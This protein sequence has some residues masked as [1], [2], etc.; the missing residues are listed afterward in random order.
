MIEKPFA[1]PRGTIY[2]DENEKVSLEARNGAIQ[3]Q[4]ILH[5]AMTWENGAP[6]SPALLLTLQQLAV[7]Q[8]YRC[9]GHFRNEGVI[10]QDATSGEILFKP[11]E[12]SE[13]PGLVQEMCDYVNQNRTTRTPVHLAAYAMW[14]LNWIHPFFGG[15]GRTSRAFSYLVLCIGLRFVPPADQKTI[16]QYIEEDRGPYM[17]ALRAADQAWSEGAFDL[18]KMEKL[19]GDLLS[20]QLVALFESA[21]GESHIN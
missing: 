3:A 17:E 16:P 1:V 2:L 5:T 7:N 20:L 8:I 14:R 12:Y 11:P 4:F 6:L 15:N 21:T 19:I 9:A 13:V 18:S 10:V